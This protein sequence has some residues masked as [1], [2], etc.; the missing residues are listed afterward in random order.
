MLCHVGPIL[1][2]YTYICERVDLV[3]LQVG[4]VIY[5]KELPYI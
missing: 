5:E 2:Y 3:F 4:K 1:A